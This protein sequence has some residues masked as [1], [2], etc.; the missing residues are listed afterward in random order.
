MS[1]APIIFALVILLFGF[2]SAGKSRP[3]E[4]TITAYNKS[5]SLLSGISR[6]HRIQRKR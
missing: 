2:D 6:A 3:D 5:T 1:L 4:N